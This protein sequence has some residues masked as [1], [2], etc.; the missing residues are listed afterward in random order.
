MSQQD[1]AHADQMET[2]EQAFA[3]VPTILD[4]VWLENPEGCLEIISGNTSVKSTQLLFLGNDSKSL[5]FLF[6]WLHTFSRLL[7]KVVCTMHRPMKMSWPIFLVTA[8]KRCPLTWSRMW[9][10]EELEFV[11]I[12]VSRSHC[13]ES[14]SEFYKQRLWGQHWFVTPWGKQNEEAFS[15]TSPQRE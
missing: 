1:S 10:S 2:R 5:I 7:N 11:R 15:K 8:V 12:E 14:R 9:S 4:H 6:R 13:T 3:A